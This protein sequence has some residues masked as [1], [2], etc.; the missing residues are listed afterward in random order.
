MGILLG[1]LPYDVL[2]F[3][4]TSLVIN[5]TPRKQLWKF[6]CNEAEQ[7]TKLLETILSGVF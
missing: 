1:I 3:K 7:I 4:K 5:D 6:I 2:T